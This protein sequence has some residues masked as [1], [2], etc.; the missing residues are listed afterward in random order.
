MLRVLVGTASLDKSL[1]RTEAA[2]RRLIAEC[3]DASQIADVGGPTYDV[4]DRPPEE[5]YADDVALFEQAEELALA[6]CEDI[7]LGG[8]R[9]EEPCCGPSGIWH[10]THPNYRG[11][12]PRSM[13]H[14]EWQLR[15][16]L[17]QL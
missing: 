8:G 10:D 11:G 4:S 7:Y 12:A 1:V 3:T 14:S 16:R 5:S 15:R 9:G 17:E 2:C 6:M 13:T